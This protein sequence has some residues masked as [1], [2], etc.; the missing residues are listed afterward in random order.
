MWLRKTD[1]V[2]ITGGATGL[3]AEIAREFALR[4]CAVAVLDV[5][6]PQA[7]DRVASALYFQ[8]DIRDLTAVRACRASIEDQLGTVSVLVN[9]AAVRRPWKPVLRADPEDIRMVIE[10][11]LTGN[12]L[13]TQVFLES[14]FKRQRG[15][16]V[17]ISSALSMQSPAGLAAYGAS[18]AGILGVYES[19]TS[20]F[21]ARNEIRTLLVC[22]GQLDTEMFGDVK[23]PSAIV[24]PIVSRR[25]LAKK[26]VWA[27]RRGQRG[28]LYTPYYVHFLPYLRALPISFTSILRRVSGMDQVHPDQVV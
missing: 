16:I 14:M 4:G 23:T 25:R 2:C 8:V 22:P 12:L 10:V 28:S 19:L 9:N 26:V 21:S 7:A 15:M 17:F 3:G 1:V 18:K 5:Q 6:L 11:N 20:E 27:V 13:A 24:A